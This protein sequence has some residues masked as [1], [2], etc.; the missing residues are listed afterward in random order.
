MDQ[1]E[2]I[3]R[4]KQRDPEALK[5]AVEKY[6]N[7]LYKVAI[8]FMHDQQAADDI[9]QDVFIKLWENAPKLNFDKTQ[10]STWLYRVTVNHCINQVK[11]QKFKSLFQD[12]SKFTR[13]NDD[14]T[15]EVEIQDNFSLNPQQYTENQELRQIIEKAI[16]SLPKKQRIAFIL[17]KYRNMSAK[18]A[19]EIMDTSPANVDVL[20]HRAK[21]NLQKF[22]LKNY[23]N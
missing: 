8:G 4:L 10:L 23:K 3:N 18:Q 21:K 20:V 22:I 12:M 16:N 15:I 14:G 17:T 6:S 19:A 13:K 5:A 2:L 1:N 7:L 9:V 11:R